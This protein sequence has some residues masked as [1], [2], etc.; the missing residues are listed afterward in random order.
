MDKDVWRKR[1]KKA[2]GCRCSKKRRGSPKHGHGPCS[3][4]CVRPTVRVRREVSRMIRRYLAG[5]EDDVSPRRLRC[6]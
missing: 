4:W 3:Q 2:S 5:I 1:K 6:S